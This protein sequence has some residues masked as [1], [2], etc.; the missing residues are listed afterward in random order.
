[1]SVETITNLDS[2]TELVVGTTDANSNAHECYGQRSVG[3]DEGKG[4]RENGKRE[5]E[6][7]GQSERGGFR[8]L[9]KG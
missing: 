9:P 2:G 3:G 5:T 4:E 8:K 7:K 1:M 6:K